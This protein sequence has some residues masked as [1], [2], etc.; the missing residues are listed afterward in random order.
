MAYRD[1]LDALEARHAALT[2]EVNE[3]TRERDDVA[4]LL[5]SARA[6]E[7]ERRRLADLVASAPARARRRQA[8]VGVAVAVAATVALGGLAWYRDTHN[9]DRAMERAMEQFD[10]FA[11]QMCMC[12]DLACSQKV[13]DD[14][15]K[16]SQQ[17]AREFA[18]PPKPDSAAMHRAEDIARRLSDC[19]TQ[20]YKINEPPQ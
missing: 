2:A 9:R 13:S 19:M 8:F 12:K 15:M 3:R 11:D 14:M 18:D 5:A 4:Q 7:A 16:W 10:R 1:D 17:M 6:V 20:I